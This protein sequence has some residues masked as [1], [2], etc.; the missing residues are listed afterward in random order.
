MQL[1]ASSLSHVS[2]F[3]ETP[4][5]HS[6]Q[7]IS[8]HSTKWKLIWIKRSPYY[9]S[10]TLERVKPIIWWL[11]LQCEFF[12][13]LN[14]WFLSK[15]KSDREVNFAQE[16]GNRSP[17]GFWNTM[18]QAG[19]GSLSQWGVLGRQKTTWKRVYIC[20]CM[21]VCVKYKQDKEGSRNRCVR[22]SAVNS[23][24][25]ALMFKIL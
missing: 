5:T 17:L 10:D 20:V 6:S 1:T 14:A 24:G 13:M 22:A 19:P 3:L 12:K 21:C 18:G 9:D 11:I 8:A 16:R 23:A 15:L 4:R 2:A 25:I 7:N